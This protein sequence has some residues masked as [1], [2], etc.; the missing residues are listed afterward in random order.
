MQKMVKS[1]LRHHRRPI[2]DRQ[3]KNGMALLATLMVAALLAMT[4]CGS[5]D[6]VSVKLA[7]DWYPNANHAGLY[8]A[9]ENGYF[10][11]EGIDLDMYTPVDPTTVNQTVAAGE[12]DFGINYQPDVLIARSQGVSVVSVAALVQHPLNS[13]QTLK[14]SGITRPRDLVGKK[15][16][17]PGIPLNE[18]LLDTMLKSDGVVRGLDEVELVNV[19]FNLAEM[20]IS[21]TVDACIGCYFSHESFLIENQGHPVHIMR[22]EEWGVPDFYELVLVTSQEMLDENPDLVLRFVRAVVKGYQDAAADPSGAVDILLRSTNQEVDEAIE[23]PGVLVIAPLWDEGTGVGTQTKER[24]TKFADW[25]HAQGQLE[26]PIDGSQAF[27]NR[28]V[29]TVR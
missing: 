18:P 11:E 3:L 1:E 28:F 14:A 13:I 23:R 25:L 5:S 22:M 26:A 27:T 6:N 15:V 9:M 7:L 8:V 2:K 4:A 21:G 12:D 19:G 17:Y 24:W 29:E 16:G 20:L 10:E